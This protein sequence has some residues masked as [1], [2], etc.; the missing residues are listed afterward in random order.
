MRNRAAIAVPFALLALIATSSIAAADTDRVSRTIRLDSGG[1]LIL[2]SFSGRVT[3]VGS[4]RNDVSIEATRYGSREALAR[5][6]L[7]IDGGNSR[8]RIE[9]RH[10]DSSM[11]SGWRGRDR[12]DTVEADFEIKVP[13]RVNLDI[14][15]FSASLD[16]ESV[17]GDHNVHTFSSRTRLDN[18]NGSIRAKGFSG[19]FDLRST[20]WRD[21]QVIDVETFSGRVQLRIP[22]SARGTIDFESFSGALDANMPIVVQTANRRRITGRLGSSASGEGSIRVK[23]FSGSVSLDR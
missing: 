9:Q 7:E 20:T 5:D 3:I 6:P 17:D 1:T 21:R 11:W 23:T 19:P 15:L 4:D 13:R 2:K 18:V 14:D 8:V 22:D 10:T 16:V 12:D